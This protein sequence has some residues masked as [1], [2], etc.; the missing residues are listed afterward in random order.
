MAFRTIGDIISAVLAQSW[1][2]VAFAV[3]PQSNGLYLIT[4]NGAPLWSFMMET[5][6]LLHLTDRNGTTERTDPTQ[7]IQALR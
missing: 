7:F 2:G 3:T 1:P 4:R 5:N 6:G